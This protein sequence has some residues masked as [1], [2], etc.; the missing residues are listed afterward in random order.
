MIILNML[1]NF[2]INCNIINLM[3][4]SLDISQIDKES[5]LFLNPFFKD[6]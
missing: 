4:F 5:L 1:I 2:N 3:V 6:L